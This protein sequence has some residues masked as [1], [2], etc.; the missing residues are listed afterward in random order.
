MLVE[1]QISPR[2]LD[3]LSVA[4]HLTEEMASETDVKHMSI[5]FLPCDAAE[6]PSHTV[7]AKIFYLC[8]TAAQCE[9]AATNLLVHFSVLN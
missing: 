8:S 2:A 6:S 3:S 4:V 9:G 1:S 7:H 5:K